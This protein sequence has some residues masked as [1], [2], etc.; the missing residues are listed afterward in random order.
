MS[1]SPD[2]SAIPTRSNCT[3]TIARVDLG[4]PNSSTPRGRASDEYVRSTHI[5]VSVLAKDGGA[6]QTRFGSGPQCAAPTIPEWMAP[7]QQSH[8]RVYA[9]PAHPADDETHQRRGRCGRF[10]SSSEPHIRVTGS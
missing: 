5:T 7:D 4:K 6:S 8:L 9:D 10:E 2:L 3:V 1:P